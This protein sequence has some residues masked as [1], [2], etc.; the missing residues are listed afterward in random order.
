M[1]GN[2]RI[3][4]SELDGRIERYVEYDDKVCVQN[5]NGEYN[6]ARFVQVSDQI[7]GEYT[8]EF[9]HGGEKPL[10][11]YWRDD[12]DHDDVQPIDCVV[13]VK[14]GKGEYSFPASKVWTPELT[15]YDSVGESRAENLK[16]AGFETVV[17]LVH[18]TPDELAEVDGFG[19]DSAMTLKEDVGYP[20]DAQ[21]DRACPIDGCTEIVEP[22]DL[23]DHA[24]SEHGWWTPE[25]EN[26]HG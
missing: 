9:E 18:A 19:P 7:M 4:L 3:R 15:N 20:P 17:D 23:Y 5:A 24:I 12:H 22:E 26:N 6:T 13:V 8:L 16:D 25:L 1:L 10:L 14:Q 2:D 11:E 21:P